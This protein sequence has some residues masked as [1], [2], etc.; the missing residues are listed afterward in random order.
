MA[1]AK[2]GSPPYDRLKA[3]RIRKA[4]QEG[5]P[6]SEEKKAW[7]A[8]YD[9]SKGKRPLEVPPHVTTQRI[10]TNP[11][12]A[13]ATSVPQTAP[14]P[15]EVPPLG[16]AD[17]TSFAG[18]ASG[19]EPSGSSSTA[20][21]GP[22][23]AGVGGAPSATSQKEAAVSA[24][25][26]M[27]ATAWIA[28]M[29][30]LRELTGGTERMFPDDFVNKIWKPAATRLGVKYLPDSAG[31]DLAD[32][33][34]VIGPP[35]GTVLAL[36]KAV[37]AKELA[38]ADPLAQVEARKPESPPVQPG[39]APHAETPPTS[40]GIMTKAEIRRAKVDMKQFEGKVF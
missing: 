18:H 33:V 8:E 13:T 15:M 17:S 1:G 36:R 31:S 23:H 14:P 6:V 11:I 29:D 16:S 7:L 39:D 3:H 24:I 2:K 35:A 22:E 21:S 25:V 34:I 19:A 28:G 30:K 5:K 27:A 12:E 32:A 37:A 4:L 38:A 10:E 9:A 26:E 40:N 20:G